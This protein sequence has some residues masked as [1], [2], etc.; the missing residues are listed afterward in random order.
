MQIDKISLEEWKNDITDEIV[1]KQDP[2]SIAQDALAKITPKLGDNFF[3]FP[4]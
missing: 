2:S 4:F 1:S 3:V